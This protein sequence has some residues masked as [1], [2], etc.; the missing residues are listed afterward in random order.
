MNPGWWGRI[1][2]LMR[3][4]SDPRK[5]EPAPVRVEDAEAE[6]LRLLSGRPS[7]SFAE[8]QRVLDI[9]GEVFLRAAG[10]LLLREPGPVLADIAERTI[11]KAA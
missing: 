7:H 10:T 4:D 1:R 6:A 5:A 2:G 11:R 9:E 3:W 8:L